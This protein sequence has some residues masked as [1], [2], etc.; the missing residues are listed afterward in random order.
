MEFDAKEINEIGIIRGS[1]QRIVKLELNHMPDDE[2]INR[3]DAGIRLLSEDDNRRIQNFTETVALILNIWQEQ[4]NAIDEFR[5]EPSEANRIMLLE[6]SEVLWIHTNQ[7]VYL[8]QRTNELKIANFKVLLPFL[9]VNIF[10]ITI[11]AMLIKRYVRDQ[12]ETTINYDA[13]TKVYNRHYFYQ[14]LEKEM[15]RGDRYEKPLSF[16]AFDIDNFK[17]V[18]DTFGHD[19]G[20]SVL[21]ELCRLCEDTIRKSDIF[22]RIGGEEFVIL[23]TETKLEQAMYIAEKIRN[24]IDEYSFK[25]VGH[26]T[27]SLGI[28]EYIKGDTKDALYKRADIALYKAKNSGKNRVEI[29]MMN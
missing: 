15:Y 27:V 12:L 16:I 10:L 23:A 21:I 17:K 2:L 26:I 14:V 8:T 5:R 13:L 4:K 29:N 11:I 7:A 28:T 19:V 1:I 18:N 9:S 24:T 22:A 20:D 25:T 6:I 3:I